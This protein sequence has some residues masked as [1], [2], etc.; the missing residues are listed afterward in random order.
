MFGYHC[1]LISRSL[2]QNDSLSP[3]IYQHFAKQFSIKFDYRCLTVKPHQL[4]SML[5]AMNNQNMRGFNI[6][7]PYKQTMM[8]LLDQLS[9]RAQRA[10]AVN[11]VSLAPDGYRIG[12][13]SDGIGFLRDIRCL[14]WVLSNKRILLLG[15]G[16]V[17][18]SLVEALLNQHVGQIVI[19]NRSYHKASGWVQHFKNSPVIACQLN[20]LPHDPFDVIIHATSSDISVEILNNIQLASRSYAYDVNYRAQGKLNFL[21]WAQKQCMQTVDGLGMLIEQAAYS[22]ECWFGLQPNTEQVKKIFSYY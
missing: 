6:T 15:A 16:G 10:N 5:E 19:A 17:C 20:D 9:Q 1:R 11:I 7:T 4:S 13:N 3:T 18:G 22:F 2:T 12:D 21:K 8:P 14:N